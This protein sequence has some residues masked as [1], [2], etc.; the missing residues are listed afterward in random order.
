MKSSCG[1][2]VLMTKIYLERASR[3]SDG[4]A[5]L[6][7]QSLESTMN[8]KM[9]HGG[10]T[11]RELLY[12]VASVGALVCRPASA[13]SARAFLVYWGTYT[14]GGGQFGNGESKGIYVSRMEGSKLSEPELAAET[15]NPSWLT[16]H[17]N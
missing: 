2:K 13:A 15:P 5:A 8:R 11:R 9:E 16:L 6:L 7:N 10:F 4:R 17:P 12:E 1:I 3:V 14:E